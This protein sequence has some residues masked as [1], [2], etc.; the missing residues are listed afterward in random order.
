MKYDWNIEKVRQAVRLNS[1]YNDVL[2]QLK[3]PVRGNNCG[4]LKRIIADNN[5]DISHFTGR[6]SSYAHPNK[7]TDINTILIKPSSIKSSVL[8]Q[9]LI[10]FGIKQNVCEQCGLSEWRGSPIVIQLHHKNGD[11]TDNTL[12]NLQMLCPNC[13][14]QTDTYSNKGKKQNTCIICGKPI[15]SQAKYCSLCGYTYRKKRTMG[16]VV[17]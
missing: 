14:S 9:R 10:E 1:C 16:E 3:I 2:R 11:P 13:H 17:G 6:A 4:T 12:D 5:I 15:T 7:I 8:K